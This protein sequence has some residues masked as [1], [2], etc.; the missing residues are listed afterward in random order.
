MTD[1]EYSIKHNKG[2]I[3]III[4]TLNDATTLPLILQEIN[5]LE[6]VKE[7][8][9][10]DGGSVDGTI[11]IAERYGVR[12]IVKKHAS[13][14]EAVKHGL[15]T[16]TGDFIVLLD[17]NATYNPKEIPNLINKLESDEKTVAVLG[18]RPERPFIIKFLCWLICKFFKIKLRDISS[19]IAIRKSVL[20]KFDLRFSTKYF[21]VEMLVKLATKY[22]IAEVDISLTKTSTKRVPNIQSF[23]NAILFV[24]RLKRGTI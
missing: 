24:I 21:V 23:I 22:R 20:E 16:A 18:V 12:V 8:I 14:G 4:P 17:G 9:V 11:E 7:V 15:K 5:E 3:S 10:V 6:G 2:R 13:Y 19:F 1:L